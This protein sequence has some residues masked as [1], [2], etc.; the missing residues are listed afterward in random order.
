MKKINGIDETNSNSSEKL[1]NLPGW[2]VMGVI[3]DGDTPRAHIIPVLSNS[4]SA[5]LALAAESQ[6]D[7]Q[8]VGVLSEIE[9]EGHLRSIQ[10]H[11]KSVSSNL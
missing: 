2:I 10:E 7:F 9:L 3:T 4:P 11:R 8:P 6:S 1:Q 5:A